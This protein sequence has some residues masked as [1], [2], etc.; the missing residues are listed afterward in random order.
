MFENLTDRL[1][2]AFDKLTSKG[3]LQE[4]D[5]DLALREVRIALM[6]ADV[7]LKVAKQ[8][9]NQIKE[10]ISE[11]RA[12]ESLTPA[13]Q[14]IQVVHQELVSLLGSDQ[15]KLETAS[16]PP[17]IYMLVGLQGSGKTTTAAKLALYLRKQGARPLLVA[18]DIYRPAAIK[19][20]QT[21]GGSLNIPV[22]SEGTS[23]PPENIATNAIDFAKQSS[24]T[25][26]ILDTAGRLHIDEAMMAELVR[27]RD[28]VS[29]TE[30]LLVVDAMTGQEAVKVAE[31]FHNTL[32]VTG[33][34]MTKLD[35]DARGGA[36]LSIRAV[37]GVPIKMIGTGERPDAFEPL[38]PDRLA[39]R[40]LGLGD[41]LTLIERAQA[42]FD[43]RK[44]KE[45]ERK[46]RTA[47][48]T[49]EDF[50]EQLQTMKRMG[51]LSQLLEMLPGVGS[52]I[53]RQ[54]L[55]IDDR[56][57]KKVEAII[58]SMTPEERQH[59]E[60]IKG[61]RRRRIAAGSG[62]TVADVNALLNQFNQMQKMMKQIT[63]GR[64]PKLPG[65]FG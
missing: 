60:I 33:V 3:K 48:F 19:Q 36:A 30:I 65:L 16:T 31:Q 27:V 44:A 32:G 17:T 23:V 45:L 42:E 57:L 53:R 7:N 59:P 41:M 15:C 24:L 14:I 9:I 52:A 29:P 6:E 40:I 2:G 26:V 58:L 20:L 61:S 37:T 28:K 63:S 11:Q 39:S 46:M 50:Y 25:H 21:L 4:S 62:T 64:I 5:V 18:A 35:G 10:K 1:Q 54:D 49:L 51:P 22:Y 55:Q 34:I 47:T 13:Q 38:I 8:F 43:E 56:E 12:L